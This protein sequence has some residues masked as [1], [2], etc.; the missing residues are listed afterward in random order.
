MTDR[1]HRHPWWQRLL[2]RTRHVLDRAWDEIYWHGRHPAAEAD[3]GGSTR[4]GRFIREGWAAEQAPEIEADQELQ[5]GQSGSTATAEAETEADA[6]P[7]WHE[8]ANY[9]GWRY[10]GPKATAEAGTAEADTSGGQV[11]PQRDADA[12]ATADPDSTAQAAADDSGWER[13][14]RQAE[15]DR[16][17]QEAAERQARAA[18]T[19][20][21]EA[22]AETGPVAADSEAAADTSGL[23]PAS[24]WGGPASA[25]REAWIEDPEA[26]AEAAD[27]EAEAQAE[28]ETGREMGP[29]YYT[30]APGSP[31]H[32]AAYERH[33][34][35]NADLGIDAVPGNPE[36]S[37]QADNAAELDIDRWQREMEAEGDRHAEAELPEAA[38]EAEEARTAFTGPAYDR[39]IDERAAQAENEARDT[40]PP[41][42][43]TAQQG[44]TVDRADYT[45]ARI[46]EVL[47]AGTGARHDARREAE[48]QAEIEAAI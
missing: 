31:E 33:F 11:P 5:T 34:H 41:P 18:R 4:P 3:T 22:A 15:E 43:V 19:E 35:A 29:D 30:A 17:A 6:E 32:R 46:D 23:S 44:R 42:S 12:E 36:A 21:A 1:T 40:D 47:A 16:Q 28:A 7:A 8:K 48:Q 10:P 24:P 9:G 37:Y 13:F 25:A 14:I 39:W 20:T 45:I 38:W 26:E 27:A 2:G